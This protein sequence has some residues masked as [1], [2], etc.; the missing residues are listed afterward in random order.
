MLCMS[1]FYSVFNP[2]EGTQFQPSTPEQIQA[3]RSI[4]IQASSPWR[5]SVGGTMPL[6]SCL[7]GGDWS[8]E[9]SLI[10]DWD[11][12]TVDISCICKC[13]LDEEARSPGFLL[14]VG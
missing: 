11:Q 13:C 6:P 12:M 8:P 2:H 9:L 3:F 7:Y 4:L 14:E 1:I 5:C 10:H